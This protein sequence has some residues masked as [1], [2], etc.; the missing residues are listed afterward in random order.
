MATVNEARCPHD[1]VTP[2]LRHVDVVIVCDLR[3]P[4]GTSTSVAHEVIA[5]AGAG[6]QV[7]LAHLDSTS[8]RT[9][10]P[11]HP[12]L[13]HLIDAGTATLLLP[14][15]A[16][17]ARLVEVRHPTVLATPLG[18]RLP[19]TA[20]QVM[21]VAGQVP[22]DR[23]GTVHYDPALVDAHVVAAFGRRGMWAPISPV[24]RAALQ[25]AAKAAAIRLTD[26]DWVEVIDPAAWTV[27]RHGVVD[28]ERPVI[29]RHSR[30]SAMKWPS[31]PADLLAAYP[32]DGS[33]RVR[34]L[35]GTTGVAEVLGREPSTWEVTP[36]GGQ[37]AREFLAGIDVF[38]YQHHPDLVE[39]FGRTVLEAMAAGVPVVV[40]PAMRT[41]FG[42]AACYAEPGRVQS[43]V[44][45]LWS[46]RAAY[47][48]QRARGL[49]AVS[50]RFSLAAHVARTQELI[51]GP[52]GS[53]TALP[54]PST[55]AIP[56]RQRAELP[57]VMFA[58]LGATPTQLVTL[59]GAVAAQ[60]ARTGGF[61]PVV[62]ATEAPPPVAAELGVIVETITHR[63]NST[64]PAERWPEYAQGRLSQLARRHGVTSITVTD[65]AHPDAALALR[66]RPPG[67][68]P[69]DQ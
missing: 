45:Q 63:R 40:P 43:C 49:A 8:L 42:D 2:S 28:A 5:A 38:V 47:E 66:I 23:D 1:H 4:G 61:V 55:A 44:R 41:L 6:Y 24:V 26:A 11:L 57:T 58:A 18:G 31:N 48:A 69:H 13:R 53:A 67:G 3:F 54:A 60:R 51:G 16:V 37:D 14:G 39:A 46:D 12:A 30:P 25:P 64:L 59:I 52:G 29:G 62:V 17:R 27:E 65:L 50:E 34:V 35:G 7:G 21:V 10:R 32:D 68:A 33:V 15:Q 36:F 20:Q 9:D 22:F 56:P 19:I